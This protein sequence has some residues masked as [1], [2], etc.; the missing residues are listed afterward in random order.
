MAYLQCL[1]NRFEESQ[2]YEQRPPGVFPATPPEQLDR[3]RRPEG[4]PAWFV[5]GK[6]F[7]QG[8]QTSGWDAGQQPG[9]DQEITKA[10]QGFRAANR[11][12]ENVSQ[13]VA[14]TGF[15]RRHFEDP[16]LMQEFQQVQR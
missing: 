16:P 7:H 12:S 15:G 6:S 1:S 9:E 10:A 13:S 2:K 5:S 8:L 3:T 14:C 4:H 11:A